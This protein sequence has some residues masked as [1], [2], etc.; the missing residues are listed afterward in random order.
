MIILYIVISRKAWYPTQSYL[1][2]IHI[3]ID[4]NILCNQIS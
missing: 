2:F 1:F 3:K 4:Q